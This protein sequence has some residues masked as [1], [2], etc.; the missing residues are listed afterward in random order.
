MHRALPALTVSLL[1][2]VAGCPGGVQAP[3]GENSESEVVSLV[4]D[5]NAS[6][7]RELK[8][9][10]RRTL[11]NASSYRGRY[12]RSEDGN[13]TYER[14]VVLDRDERRFIRDWR[15]HGLSE[16]AGFLN[17]SGYYRRYRMTG[18]ES[19]TYT[20][21][22]G[23]NSRFTE[24]RRFAMQVPLPDAYVLERYD[25]EYVRNDGSLY[26]FEADGLV[27]SDNATAPRYNWE[28]RDATT[29]SA[30]LV[31]HEAGYVRSFSSTVTL[32]RGTRNESVTEAWTANLWAVNETHAE[33]P[34]W[35]DSAVEEAS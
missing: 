31:V 20:A 16:G 14:A 35:V 7:A 6:D 2:F 4:A 24:E 33:K 27:D 13:T 18:A 23:Q 12:E 3:E 34:H 32:T 11:A 8:R 21:A 17:A 15:D 28:M 1:L 19:F 30:R 5:M 22:T 26:Y 9:M 29:A 10:H 25:F